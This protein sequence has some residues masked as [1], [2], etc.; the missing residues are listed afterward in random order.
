ML[1]YN[2]KRMLEN[3]I[4]REILNNQP[5]GINTRVLITNIVNTLTPSIPKLNR[6]HAAGMLNWVINYNP[7]YSH[8]FT[9]KTPGYSVVI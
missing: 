6:N 9:V 7:A 8:Q 1:N 2:Q 3:A 5:L 4:E